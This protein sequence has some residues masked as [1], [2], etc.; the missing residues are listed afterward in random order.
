MEILLD[1]SKESLAETN[2]RGPKSSW[3]HVLLYAVISLNGGF[4]GPSLGQIR[5]RQIALASLS[6]KIPYTDLVLPDKRR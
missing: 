5:D 2:S 4:S 3:S 6:P 1:H